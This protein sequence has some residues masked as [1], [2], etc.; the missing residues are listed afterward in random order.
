M[1]WISKYLNVTS[2]S[3]HYLLITPISSSLL[4]SHSPRPIISS[5]IRT[6]KTLN[7]SHMEN[8]NCF[9]TRFSDSHFPFLKPSDPLWPSESGL[10]VASQPDNFLLL[11]PTWNLCF[12]LG[13]LL[14]PFPN[15]F[16]PLRSFPHPFIPLLRIYWVPTMSIFWNQCLLPRPLIWPSLC[17][18]SLVHCLLLSKNGYL[19]NKR[20]HVCYSHRTM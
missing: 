13:G 17:A 16:S 5:L 11:L 12:S 10:S 15:S 2:N 14:C 6:I 7:T 3:S 20:S 4:T 18:A 19:F 1:T 9:Q 8:D